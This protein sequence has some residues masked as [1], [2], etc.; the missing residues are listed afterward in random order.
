MSIVDKYLTHTAYLME[1]EEVNIYGEYNTTLKPIRCRMEMSQSYLGEMTR[2]H[3]TKRG[4]RSMVLITEFQAKA[5]MFC[6]EP[7]SIGQRIQF[8]GNEYT[9]VQ[10][11]EILNL[12]G[13]TSH[14]EVILA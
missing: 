5:L 8:N 12:D 6:R 13:T 2:S 7:V 14:Y 11:S 4:V 10:V 3:I 9:A 1:K